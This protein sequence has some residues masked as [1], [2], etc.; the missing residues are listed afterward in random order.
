MNNM[1]YFIKLVALG[2]I[3]C[4]AIGCS[5]GTSEDDAK[6]NSDVATGTTPPP[7]MEG[8]A[9][10]GGGSGTGGPETPSTGP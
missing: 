1:K 2:V 3:A 10:A 8:S 4:C 9:N 5:S 7:Q 6:V